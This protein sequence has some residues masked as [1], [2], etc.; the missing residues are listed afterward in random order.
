MNRLPAALSVAGLCLALGSWAARGQSALI[1][2][3][4]QV[5]VRSRPSAAGE[6]V[7]RLRRAERVNRLPATPPV[8]TPRDTPPAWV[9]I[10]LPPGTPVWVSGTHRD[11]VTGAVLPERLNVRAGPSEDYGV[12]GTVP[13]GTVLRALR[14]RHGWVQIE[15]PAGLG[16]Y[17]AARFLE[18]A[19]TA[20]PGPGGGPV[21]VPAQSAEPPPAA[22][23]VAVGQPVAPAP[24][25]PPP[26]RT[27]P[28]GSPGPA[29]AARSGVASVPAVVPA[30]VV[31]PAVR[32][33]EVP[34]VEAVEPPPAAPRIV[35][36]EG[37]VRT[38]L[39]IQAPTQ[40]EL[41]A[42][43]TGRRLNYLWPASTNIDFRPFRGTRVRVT[44]EE[45]MEP[46]W[47]VTPMIRVDRILLAP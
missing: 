15:V 3:A 46:R 45:H 32:E 17:V 35:Q 41:R 47:P 28:R 8:P 26:T 21:P 30:P 33:D 18:P 6:V 13:R 29:P 14:E 36:R 7:T 34:P 43:D 27:P 2:N 42:T 37:V 23:P 10:E 31:P 44:G 22:P 12:L 19:P 11:P 9:R 24:Q 4:D 39:S 25:P 5:N 20:S 1:V 16:G 38:T 40:F